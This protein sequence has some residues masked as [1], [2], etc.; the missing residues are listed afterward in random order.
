M[1]DDCWAGNIEDLLGLDPTLDHE[2]PEKSV[3]RSRCRG[4]DVS[5]SNFHIRLSHLRENFEGPIP[6]GVGE[7]VVLRWTRAFCMDLFGSVM[8]ADKTGDAVPAMYLQFLYN[9]DK[10]QKYDW[11]CAV[12][13][14]LYG[15]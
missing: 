12:L 5:F 4:G 6:E 1:S 15:N 7:D 11:G 2:N 8:F 10:P 9:L 13:V 14:V 3:W